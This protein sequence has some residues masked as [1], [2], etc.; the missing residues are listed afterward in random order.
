MKFR[1]HPQQLGPLAFKHPLHRNACPLGYNLRNILRSN[2]LG[3]D[4]IRDCSLAGSKIIDLLLHLR[5]LAVTDLGHLA[6]ISGPLGI[7]GLNLIIFNLLAGSLQ[8]RQDSFLL[9]PTLTKSIAFLGER[10][11][12]FLDL[13][14]LQG[15]T[16]SLDC[17]ALDLKLTYTA[18]QLRNRFWHRVHLQTQL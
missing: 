10:F 12:F 1:L 8:F 15:H 7:M 5:H 16:L 14:R 13:V 9:V 6:I 2:S 18:I 17:L 11:Q 3:N 4:R